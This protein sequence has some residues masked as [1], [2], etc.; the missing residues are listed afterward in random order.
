MNL[1]KKIIRA[2]TS[3]ILLAG[4][5]DSLRAQGALQP[6]NLRCEARVNPLGIGNPAPELSWQLQSTGT[7]TA[8]RGLFQSAYEIQVGSAAGAADLWDSGKVV[9]SQSLNVVYA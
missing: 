1:T 3:A 4:W 2:V 7:G 6:V 5:T 8:Y 9:G